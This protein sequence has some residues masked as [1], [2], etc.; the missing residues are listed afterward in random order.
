MFKKIIWITL[1]H[2][3]LSKIFI[4]KEEEIENRCD[5]KGHKTA[6]GS[7]EISDFSAKSC[8]RLRKPNLPTTATD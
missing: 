7:P 1:I 4:D 5:A 3:I 2:L 8:Q 6:S